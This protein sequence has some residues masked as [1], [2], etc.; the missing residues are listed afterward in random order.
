MDRPICVLLF[1]LPK[2]LSEIL[3]HVLGCETDMETKVHGDQNET[4]PQAVRRNGAD[5]VITGIDNVHLLLIELLEDNPRLKIFNV[6]SCG[7][8]TFLCELQPDCEA[9]GQLAPED[10]VARI[11]ELIDV[12]FAFS[13]ERANGQRQW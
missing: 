7:R 5:I 2:L 3:A 6:Q 10:I 12:P 11:R 9:L 1:G 4:L 13:R 8:E